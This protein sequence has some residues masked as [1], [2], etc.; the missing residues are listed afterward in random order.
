[1]SKIRIL[2]LLIIVAFLTFSLR[3]TEFVT[4]V[5]QIDGASLA[6]EAKSEKTQN[7]KSD[8]QMVENDGSD[9]SDSKVKKNDIPLGQE[10]SD[11]TSAGVDFSGNTDEILQEL[12]D[13]RKAVVKR[14]ASLNQ[15]EALLQ[16]TEQQVDQK[17]GELKL[18]REELKDLLDQ[19]EEAESD[20][21]KSLVKI[22]E[23][24]KPKEAANIFN[25]LDMD[26]M[27]SVVGRM[28][29]R[30]SAPVLAAMEP[31][32]AR[33]L[34]VLLAREKELPENMSNF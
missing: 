3:V 24:M 32:K 22:Y 20:R 1:L 8:S 2:P 4:D 30:K 12:M 6:A 18:L 16:A 26:I 21:I 28:S 17:L 10:W 9:S 14:E 25:T 19:Q 33:M 27:L 7:P 23:G 5:R 11:P 15:K 29:E 34:T 13:R 31:E